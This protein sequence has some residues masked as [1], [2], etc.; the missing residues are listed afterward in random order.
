[1]K[2][3]LER[4]IKIRIKQYEDELYRLVDILYYNAGRVSLRCDTL[5]EILSFL[6]DE[7]RLPPLPKQ[8]AKS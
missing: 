6:K 8:K 1:M 5:E 4:T 7:L 2:P 3:Q